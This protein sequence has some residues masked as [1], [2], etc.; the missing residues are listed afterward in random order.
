MSFTYPVASAPRASASTELT[1]GD[2]APTLLNTFSPRGP[3][4]RKP[5]SAR[6]DPLQAHR[7]REIRASGVWITS[8]RS[9]C[10]RRDD[11][12]EGVRRR[13]DA[14]ATRPSPCRQHPSVG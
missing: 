7:E 10:R 8:V 5:P 13:R 12:A 14:R 11:D 4:T 6:C 1:S 9:G 3:W 2:E